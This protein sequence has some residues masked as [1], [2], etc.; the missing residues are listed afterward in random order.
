[1]ACAAVQSLGRHRPQL[2]LQTPRPQTPYPKLPDSSP[3]TGCFWAN[4]PLTNHSH[5]TQAT[6]P[7]LPSHPSLCPNR[8]HLRA[9]HEPLPPALFSQ[10]RA[11]YQ[12]LTAGHGTSPHTL[13]LWTLLACGTEPPTT[14]NFTIV[15]RRTVLQEYAK[16]QPPHQVAHELLYCFVSECMGAPILFPASLIPAEAGPILPYMFLI[17]ICRSLFLHATPIPLLTHS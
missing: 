13:C 12:P 16:R 5:G 1:M 14:S 2:R 3:Q 10:K 8:T 11:S 6:P 17:C 7:P 4:E 9:T 15:R